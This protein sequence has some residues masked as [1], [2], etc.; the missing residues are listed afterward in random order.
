MHGNYNSEVKNLWIQL[1]LKLKKEDII[2][3]A[4][5]FLGQI[6][7][8]KYIRPIYKA[9]GYFNKQKAMDCFEKNKGIYHPVA[10]RLIY[11]DFKKIPD[12]AFIQKEEMEKLVENFGDTVQ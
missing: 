8:M 12:S 6:G 4:E 11:D 1:A 7:R 9:Y 5:E 10:V 3:Y 2:P